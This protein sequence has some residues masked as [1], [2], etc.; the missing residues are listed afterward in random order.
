MIGKSAVKWMLPTIWKHYM[1]WQGQ[2]VGTVM[3]QLCCCQAK[4]LRCRIKALIVESDEIDMLDAKVMA[5]EEHDQVS[6]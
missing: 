6:P 5:A 1:K 2:R 4:G 3:A